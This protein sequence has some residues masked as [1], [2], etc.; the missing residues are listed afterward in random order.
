MQATAMH[1]LNLL[2]IGESGVGKSRWINAFANYLRYSDLRDAEDSELS[3]LIPMTIKVTDLNSGIEYEYST[4]EDA[5]ESY[6]NEAEPV[7]QGP[8]TYEI[9]HG[10]T[11]VRLIDTPG[12]D[13]PL[14]VDMNEQNLERALLH[15]SQYPQLHAIC[16]MVRSDESRLGER[17]VAGLQKILG[18]LH[19]SAQ[20]NVVFCL[21]SSRGTNYEPG[22]A[23]AILKK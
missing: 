20:K 15:V 13:M 21:T 11:V 16:V 1:E 23:R 8:V 18:S 5:N 7:T 3:L 17:F 2:L 14:S 4:G 10:Y 19:E 6:E 22:P 12:L 9:S